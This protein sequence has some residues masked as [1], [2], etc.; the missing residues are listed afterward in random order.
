[1]GLSW[2]PTPIAPKT[3]PEAAPKAPA[4]IA[5]RSGPESPPLGQ[6][7]QNAGGIQG[8]DFFTGP[9]SGPLHDWFDFFSHYGGQNSPSS[10][11]SFFGF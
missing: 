10:F 5:P 6:P 9:I 1:M 3:L 8:I 4:P 2:H 7:V 11:Q